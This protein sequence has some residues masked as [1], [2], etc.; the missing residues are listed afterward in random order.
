MDIQL[1]G[2]GINP[3]LDWA[4]KNL[5]EYFEYYHFHLDNGQNFVVSADGIGVYDEFKNDIEEFKKLGIDY[6]DTWEE[7]EYNGWSILYNSSIRGAWYCKKE[8]MEWI[9]YITR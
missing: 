7:L 6:S 5:N 8:G 2:K 4:D 9:V 3:I 1:S